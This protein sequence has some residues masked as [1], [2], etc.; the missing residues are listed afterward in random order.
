MAEGK[1]LAAMTAN[2]RNGTVIE[3]ER[4]REFAQDIY[5]DCRTSLAT[6]VQC[7]QAAGRWMPDDGIEKIKKYA[8]WMSCIEHGGK[9]STPLI[10]IS[11]DSSLK[12][13]QGRHR[14]AV[15]ETLGSDFVWFCCER[16][17]KMR[18]LAQLGLL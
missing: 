4:D 6:L 11:F 18:I 16:E 10:S 5:V 2:L 14:L 12:V 7:L 8:W 3:F 17:E 1:T 9:V 15:I 13:E